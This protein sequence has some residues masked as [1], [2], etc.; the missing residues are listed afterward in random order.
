MY[1][2]KKLHINKRVWKQLFMY[3]GRGSSW[4][5]SLEP[6]ASTYLPR[7]CADRI[8]GGAQV[9]HDTTEAGPM[10]ITDATLA[11]SEVREDAERKMY[12]VPSGAQTQ[13]G[14]STYEIASNF[15]IN[16]VCEI[17]N[18]KD[19]NDEPRTGCTI[20]CE[21]LEGNE[22]KYYDVLILPDAL[23]TCSQFEQHMKNN[24][25]MGVFCRNMKSKHLQSILQPKMHECL[26]TQ[27]VRTAL[28]VMGRQ[29]TTQDDLDSSYDFVF[30]NCV[31][32]SGGGYEDVRSLH[33]SKYRI[34]NRIFNESARRCFGKN[35]YPA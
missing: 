12:L 1:E 14:E 30:G 5:V 18:W 29:A 3:S 10:G 13:E 25:H 6:P 23:G 17:I 19:N 33:K 8:F 27:A 24:V 22:V 20:E 31:L 28:T 16:N 35:N 26:R 4:A 15:I 2:F 9:E 21:M 7:D 11:S 32:Q 34:V